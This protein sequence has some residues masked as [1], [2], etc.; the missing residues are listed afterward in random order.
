MQTRYEKS[1]KERAKKNLL[2]LHFND[3][4]FFFFLHFL[5]LLFVLFFL[6]FLSLSP[7]IREY[8]LGRAHNNLCCWTNTCVQ[9]KQVLRCERERTHFVVLR[10]LSR[11]P[12]NQFFFFYIVICFTFFYCLLMNDLFFP[13]DIFIIVNNCFEFLYIYSCGIGNSEKQIDKFFF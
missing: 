13:I 3:V 12:V 11:R 9:D 5:L 2:Y 10:I 6:V 1:V 7:S 8:F 4:R